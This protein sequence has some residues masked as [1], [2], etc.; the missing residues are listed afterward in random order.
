MRKPRSNLTGKKFGKLTVLE[1][2]GNSRWRCACD[3][4]GESVVYTANLN[5]GNT[6]SCGCVK[7]ITSSKR[8]TVHGYSGTKIHRSWMN[9]KRRCLDPKY[10]SYKDYGAKGITIYAPWIKDIKAFAEHLGE[11]PSEEHSVDRIDNLKGYEPG[12]IRWADRWEQANNK[13]TNVKVVFQEQE[14]SSIS[15]FCRWISSQCNIKPNYIKR[16]LQKLL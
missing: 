2:V 14:F 3:C 11:P 10:P 9:I 5:R 4:G 7:K 16:E 8:A 15:A 12:N 6:A 1:F 13:T